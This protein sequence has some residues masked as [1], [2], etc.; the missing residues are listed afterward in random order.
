MTKVDELKES[1]KKRI[2]SGE[3]NDGGALPSRAQFA[4]EFDV[5]P[6]TVSSAIRSLQKEGV[7][8]IIQGKG[9]YVANREQGEA[10]VALAD[11]VVGLTGSYLP[12][13]EESAESLFSRS[14]FDGIREAGNTN[15]TSL[16]LVPD[17]PGPSIAEYCRRLN[18][19]GLVFL[20]A[21]QYRAALEL[22][23]AGFPVILSNRLVG[24]TPLNY[25][26]YDNEFVVQEVVR[27][28]AEVG[29]RHIGVL[30]F[31]GSVPDYFRMMKLSFM[32]A[33]LDRGILCN[34]NDYW[35]MVDLSAPGATI[36]SVLSKAVDELLSLP[37]RPTALFCWDFRFVEPL[38][39]VLKTKGV[40]VPQDLSLIVSA[41][42]DEKDAGFSGFAMPHRELGKA[43]LHHLLLTIRNPHHCVQELLRPRYVER[44]SVC[45]PKE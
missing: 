13:Q 17:M 18:I 35:K 40:K 39:E 30:A 28:L 43:L 25:I 3:W 12:S 31:Q 45:S 8:R 1:L 2:D 44:G 23:N 15:R 9:A 14:I 34:V 41:Y 42:E 20:G 22:K 36:F 4:Q 32:E 7:L 10:S 5:S 26:D 11:Q 38:M 37:E 19:R 21:E 29:H 16:V 24:A 33:L 6:A 27:R